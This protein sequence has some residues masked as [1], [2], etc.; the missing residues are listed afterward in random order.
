MNSTLECLSNIKVLTNS[1]LNM[2]C[3]Q[4]NPKKHKLT[5]IYFDVLYKLFFP[6]NSTRMK[7]CIAPHNFKAI[8]GKMNPL[9]QGIN[10]GDAKDFLFFVL[11]SLHEELVI[12]NNN[13]NM[14]NNMNLNESN[15]A[16]MYQKFIC[17]FNNNQSIISTNFYGINK[18]ILTCFQCGIVKYSFESFNLLII[19]LKKAYEYKMKNNSFINSNLN[20]YEGI[21]SLSEPEIFTGEN[22]IYCNNCQKLT[23]G[24][25]C[26]TL[27]KTPNILIFILFRGKANC[28]FK[29]NF[30]F[31]GE[32]YLKGNMNFIEDFSSPTNYF[33]MGVVTHIGPSSSAGHFIAYCRKDQYSKFICYNDAIVFPVDNEN[34]V[35]GM[36]NSNNEYETKIPYI[37]FYQKMGM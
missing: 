4:L 34:D 3:G 7:K 2:A 32:L 33:L 36:N 1:I 20:L 21:A 14:I 35:Y 10:A 27:Y 18:I 9:F 17:D 29:G 37:L 19:P 31:P 28:D 30:E 24:Q 22:M 26:Q 13:Y 5:T 11:E 8:I 6:S 15:Q 25:H 23:A 12:K 16:Q